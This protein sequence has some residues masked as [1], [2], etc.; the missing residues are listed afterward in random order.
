MNALELSKKFFDRE[1]LSGAPVRFV[2]IA[3]E[4]RCASD[5]GGRWVA[6]IK[7]G[8]RVKTKRREDQDDELAACQ[9]RR[10]HGGRGTAAPRAV[11]RRNGG[12]PEPGRVIVLANR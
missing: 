6:T 7:S 8:K 9:A 5:Q 3:V 4:E 2:P 11:R 12:S 1:D 10:W